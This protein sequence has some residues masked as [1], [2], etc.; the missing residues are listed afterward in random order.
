MAV[1]YAASRAVVS[2][3]LHVVT[4]RAGSR[5]VRNQL[6]K[7]I[8]VITHYDVLKARI[9]VGAFVHN[10]RGAIDIASISKSCG[11]RIVFA[12]IDTGQC[13]ATTSINVSN[14]FDVKANVPRDNEPRIQ[15]HIQPSQSSYHVHMKGREL[16]T[17][18]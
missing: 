6:A 15:P 12:A 5:Q 9:H 1:A 18:R 3:H 7:V 2:S 10:S 13:V 17:L 11:W 14:D 16:L 8:V 4:S